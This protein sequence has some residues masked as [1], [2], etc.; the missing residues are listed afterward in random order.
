MARRTIV[1][2]PDV[3]DP[4]YMSYLVDQLEYITGLTVQKGE[5]FFINAGDGS[6]IILTSANGTKYIIVVNDDG[7]LT[8]TTVA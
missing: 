3:Y 6:E 7:S 1:R 5:Q 2:P 4:N 8:T